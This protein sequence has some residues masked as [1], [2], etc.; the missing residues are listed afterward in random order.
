MIKLIRKQEKAKKGKKK[1]M[2]CQRDRRLFFG[3][4]LSLG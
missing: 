3:E 1:K 4:W 2:S